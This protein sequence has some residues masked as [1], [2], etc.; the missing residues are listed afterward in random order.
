VVAQSVRQN[1][2]LSKRAIVVVLVVSLL[3]AA[4]FVVNAT[5]K[6]SIRLGQVHIGERGGMPTDGVSNLIGPFVGAAVGAVFA[7]GVA[8][9]MFRKQADREEEQVQVDTALAFY[10]EL[11]SDDFA[12]ARRKVTKIFES[13]RDANNLN[14]FYLDLLEEEKQPIVRV[15]SFFRRLQLAVKYRRIHHQMVLDLLAG[16]FRWW[17]EKWLDKMVPNDWETRKQID[18][19]HRW[20]QKQGK[21]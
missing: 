4:G 7:L 8:L 13:H 3:V 14:D 2:N 1:L 17:Y 21:G 15:L 10:E 5:Q 20:L 12:E 16:E 19:L 18:G 9:Y 6:G 11:A